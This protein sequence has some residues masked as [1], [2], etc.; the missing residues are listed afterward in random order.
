M[1]RA[2]QRR[3]NSYLGVT[4]HM[5]SSQWELH[6]VALGVKLTEDRHYTASQWRWTG[7]FS[8]KCRH[9]AQTMLVM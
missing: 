7:K 6:S 2:N 3:I 1:S 8:T 5:I 9:S 4:G